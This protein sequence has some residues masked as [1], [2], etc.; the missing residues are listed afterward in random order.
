MAEELKTNNMSNT[1]FK[2]KGFSPFHQE[3]KTTLAADLTKGR[4][5]KKATTLNDLTFSQAFRKARNAGVKTFT[6]KGKNYTTKVAK[7]RLAVKAVKAKKR[8]MTSKIKNK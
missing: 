3:K 6:W 5:A 2:M 1:P 7:P 4:V 8:T